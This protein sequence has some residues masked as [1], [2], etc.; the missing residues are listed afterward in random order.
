MWNGTALYGTAWNTSCQYAW[1]FPSASSRHPTTVPYPPCRPDPPA[2]TRQFWTPAG[3]R[4]LRRGSSR[5]VTDGRSHRQPVVTTSEL[6]SPTP[7]PSVPVI[8]V[9]SVSTRPASSQACRTIGQSGVLAERGRAPGRAFWRSNGPV[10]SA[11][12]SFGQHTKVGLGAVRSALAKD[13]RR[14]HLGTD[15]GDLD[16]RVRDSGIP[17][18]RCNHTRD[19]W[20]S[21]AIPRVPC[22]WPAGCKYVSGSTDC[23]VLIS[24]STDWCFVS[25]LTGWMRVRVSSVCWYLD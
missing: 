9:R 7:P 6:P 2:R 23:L 22:P 3:G 20:I 17:V 1:V 8:P 14:P 25:G 21:W 4:W 12:R 24:E 18:R 16:C 10:V 5:L 19:S 15:P 11:E 13:R